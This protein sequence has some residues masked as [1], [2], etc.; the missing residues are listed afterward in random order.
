[1]KALL[2]QSALGTSWRSDR[3]HQGQKSV[4]ALV[5]WRTE[6]RDR[7]EDNQ[8]LT[9]VDWSPIRVEVFGV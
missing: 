2:S 3:R 6:Y 7:V 8:A 4:I 1:M 9:A 5:V